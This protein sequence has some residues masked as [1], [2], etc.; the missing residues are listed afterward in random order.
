MMIPVIKD[1]KK[2]PFKIFIHGIWIP[3]SICLLI[4]S[5]RVHDELSLDP[6][7][8]PA[9]IVT[10]FQSDAELQNGYY[11]LKDTYPGTAIWTLSSIQQ[12]EDI[13]IKLTVLSTDKNQL[14]GLPPSFFLSF[15]IKEDGVMRELSRRSIYLINTSSE[16]EPGGFVCRGTVTIEHTMIPTDAL[17]IWI[18]L[19]PVES[20]EMGDT[21]MVGVNAD[22]LEIVQ[23]FP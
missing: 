21:R 18:Q 19:S 4:I 11:W 12:G 15:G 7:V 13:S 8:I 23:T 6:T 20:E 22:S 14:S 1:R 10:E 3:L 2:T 16:T 17:S 9:A 5:C